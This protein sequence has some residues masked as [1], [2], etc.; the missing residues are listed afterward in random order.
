MG[1]T[2][3]TKI[4]KRS[5]DPGEDHPAKPKRIDGSRCFAFYFPKSQRKTFLRHVS[6]MLN[7]WYHFA[8][9]ELDHEV[10]FT[11]RN[12]TFEDLNRYENFLQQ[13]LP[14]R[15]ARD[16]ECRLQI[17]SLDTEVR[18]A[19]PSIIGTSVRDSFR[20]IRAELLRS[21]TQSA[22]IDAIPNDE[23]ETS[24]T[25]GAGATAEVDHS[26]ELYSAPENSHE[27]GDNE[28]SSGLDESNPEILFSPIQNVTPPAP[29]EHADW[30]EV[31]R[32][33]W[34]TRTSEAENREPASVHD[35]GSLS[36]TRVDVEDAPGNDFI[37][38]NVSYDIDLDAFAQYMHES[39]P[40]YQHFPPSVD[41][42][43][44]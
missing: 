32:T 23:A 22:L 8:E 26:Q 29:I 1:K 40:T 17:T 6:V 42:S 13:E 11:K 21:N 30:T 33:P 12:Y 4:K 5:F 20:S 15:I 14:P 25:Q 44:P 19:L 35:P 28:I 38:S 3:L 39:Q 43:L 18:L 36:N 34:P 31:P 27:S 7:P 16:I 9:L 2:A 37:F 24:R 10:D 41:A